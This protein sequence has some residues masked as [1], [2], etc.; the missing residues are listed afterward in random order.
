MLCYPTI[1]RH[2]VQGH[3]GGTGG[4]GSAYSGAVRRA[5][6]TCSWERVWALAQHRSKQD[7]TGK[8]CKN[9]SIDATTRAASYA[10]GLKGCQAVDRIF[11][12]CFFST[13]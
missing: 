4:I 8:H 5:I 12:N 1:G 10:G 13:S 7:S 11:G 6:A 9:L 2:A 3:I